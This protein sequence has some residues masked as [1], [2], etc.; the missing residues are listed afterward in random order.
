MNISDLLNELIPKFEMDKSFNYTEYTKK[1]FEELLKMAKK[2]FKDSNELELKGF[3]SGATFSKDQKIWLAK[4][5]NS[6]YAGF[7]VF[8]IRKDYVE[9]AKK[10]PTGYLEG[11]FVED[12]FRNKGIAKQFLKLGESWCKSRGCIQ[13]GSD[14]WLSDKTSRNFHKQMGFWEEDELVHFLKDL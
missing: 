11:I 3:L 1:D 2:L 14:T 12:E 13:I 4:D 7:A 10:S 8:T 6:K 9:G 5:R